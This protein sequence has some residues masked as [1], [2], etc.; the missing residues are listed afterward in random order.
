MNTLEKYN[1]QRNPADVGRICHAPFNNL[2][3][4]NRGFVMACCSN[5]LHV[6][7]K[8]PEQ[9]I[10]QI[11]AAEKANQLREAILGN[12]FSKG[13]MGCGILFENENFSGMPATAY[14]GHPAALK[15]WPRRMEFE[16]TNTCNLECI[17]CTGEF[18]SSINDR[19]DRKPPIPN[20]YDEKFIEQ[21]KP[22]IPHLYSARFVGGEPFLISVY[23]QIWELMIQLNPSIEI[24]IQTNGTILNQKV[25]RVLD[26]LSPNI[27]VSI[28]SLDENIYKSIRVNGTLD[29]TLS[30][31][32]YFSDYCK[33]NGTSLSLSFCPMQNNWRDIPHIAMYASKIGATIFYNTVYYPANLSLMNLSAEDLDIV[34][35]Y[36]QGFSLPENTELEKSNKRKYEDQ[37]NEI[38]SFRKKA[39]I[40]MSIPVDF[41][42]IE[43][44]MSRIKKHIYSR[45][46][47]VHDEK[48]QKYDEI[49]IKIEGIMAM[50][51]E[52]NLYDSALRGLNGLSEDTIYQFVPGLDNIERAY[53]LF[54]ERILK[55]V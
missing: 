13:C 29:Q 14:D 15:S 30:N 17:M 42:T 53:N 31:I 36:L 43:E 5:K 9:T 10:E 25:K 2:F 37:L 48:P 6:L 3:F 52:E 18:S 22:Y 38:T 40:A 4:G 45:P 49:R 20:P 34:I 24:F 1:Q 33:Q 19:R 47:L 46:E 12:D 7:G 26:N 27:S 32:L 16:L 54:K 35:S 51:K 23:Y 28:D 8:Y 55:I 41:L 50:A 11:W 39:N 21:L 44:Y